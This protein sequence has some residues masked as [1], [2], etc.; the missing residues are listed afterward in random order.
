MKPWRILEF[1]RCMWGG[2]PEG[3]SQDGVKVPPDGGGGPPACLASPS[4][5][6]PISHLH[7][8]SQNDGTF[9]GII[10]SGVSC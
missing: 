2:L 1:P 9:E 7:P 3:G 4:L 8:G 5:S 6:S 10:G